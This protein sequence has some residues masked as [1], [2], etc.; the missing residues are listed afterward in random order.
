MSG[1]LI[2]GV[3]TWLR[4]IKSFISV[5]YLRFSNTPDD[6]QDG[7]IVTPLDNA[8]RPEVPTGG[9]VP[10]GGDPN[11]DLA[12]VSCWGLIKELNRRLENSWLGDVIAVTCLMGAIFGGY[13]FLGVIL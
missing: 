13:I 8:H 6:R 5:S 7:G 4:G 9:H 10:V 3:S 1:N 2:A 12:A 11:R